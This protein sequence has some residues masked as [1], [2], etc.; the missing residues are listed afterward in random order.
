MAAGLALCAW[1]PDTSPCCEATVESGSVNDRTVI[2]PSTAPITTAAPSSDTATRSRKPRDM[3]LPLV[4]AGSPSP[5]CNTR[6]YRVLPEL[7]A[8][9]SG[10]EPTKDQIDGA[11]PQA[12]TVSL[13]AVS[14]GRV[15]RGTISPRRTL[16]SYRSASARANSETT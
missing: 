16:K 3:E 5:L 6:E 4:E 9:F 10:F 13:P 11:G 15:G 8:V 1:A 12:V 2:T 14:P 7:H